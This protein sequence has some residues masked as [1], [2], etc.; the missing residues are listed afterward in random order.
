MIKTPDQ[1]WVESALGGVLGGV[2]A[3]GAGLVVEPLLSGAGLAAPLSLLGF[4]GA[5]G[6][7]GRVRLCF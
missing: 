5:R 3:G 1:G 4:A 6:T 2:G 7:V